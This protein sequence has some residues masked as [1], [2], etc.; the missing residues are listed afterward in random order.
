MEY[1]QGV[2]H[3]RDSVHRGR[4]ERVNFALAKE[5]NRLDGFPLNVINDSSLNVLIHCIFHSRI[6]SIFGGLLNHQSTRVEIRASLFLGQ[7]NLA[8]IVLRA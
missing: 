1:L 6:E 5:G 2:S 4:S 7:K 3:G 8:K